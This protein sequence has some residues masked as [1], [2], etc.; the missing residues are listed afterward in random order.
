MDL[1]E[2]ISAARLAVTAA[3]VAV[4]CYGRATPRDNFLFQRFVDE[5]KRDVVSEG[6]KPCLA[7]YLARV[8]AHDA[9]VKKLPSSGAAAATPPVPALVSAATAQDDVPADVEATAIDAAG[10]AS[11]AYSVCD[12]DVGE[13]EGESEAGAGAGTPSTAAGVDSSG[14]YHLEA[15]AAK[16]AAESC[17]RVAQKMFAA[18]AARTYAAAT[19]NSSATVPRCKD[20]ERTG[21]VLPTVECNEQVVPVNNELLPRPCAPTII[22]TVVASIPSIDCVTRYTQTNVH[23]TM[24]EM[25]HDITAMADTETW[26]FDAHLDGT[27]NHNIHIGWLEYWTAFT[28][29]NTNQLTCPC[30]NTK[31]ND[32]ENARVEHGAH[33]RLKTCVVLGCEEFKN[34]GHCNHCMKYAYA[35][36]PV[37]ISCNKGT[38]PLMKECVAV[39]IVDLSMQMYVGYYSS[40]KS[41]TT[42]MNEAFELHEMSLSPSGN[43]NVLPLALLT[44]IEVIHILDQRYLKP[45]TVIKS[46]KKFLK[47]QIELSD[48]EFSKFLTEHLTRPLL[49]TLRNGGDGETPLSAIVTKQGAGPE[50]AQTILRQILVRHQVHRFPC[51]SA[52][53][54]AMVPLLSGGGEPLK[55]YDL[56]Q[57]EIVFIGSQRCPNHF[58]LGEKYIEKVAVKAIIER[59]RTSIK[60]VSNGSFSFNGINASTGV[61]EKQVGWKV[62]SDKHGFL[63][64]LV[65]CYKRI[66][67]ED[68]VWKAVCKPINVL[69]PPMKA[70]AVLPLIPTKIARDVKS[71]ETEMKVELNETPVPIAQFMD[72]V[73]KKELMLLAERASEASVAVEVAMAAATAATAALLAATLRVL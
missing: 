63:K 25:C 17:A 69:L 42:G 37:C 2:Q 3:E 50:V 9:L 70:T 47:D 33:V 62:K 41:D 24:V 30:V 64:K 53:M 6:A 21:S 52:D 1:G 39:P 67:H 60:G 48:T 65:S 7:L 10:E 15:S 28:H 16:A 46:L 58:P 12:E 4:R 11:N 13:D 26:Y 55:Q 73:T 71:K 57:S 34:H 27:G 61:A 72:K 23:A 51:K 45:T 36:I 8:N 31:R 18:T 56:Y 44:D 5:Y 59:F 43:P 32:H 19:R 40:S 38:K 68:P 54:V 49:D 14:K 66:K 35:I 20:G 22:A 29:V